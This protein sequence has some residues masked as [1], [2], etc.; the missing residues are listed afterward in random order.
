[1]TLRCEQI[2]SQSTFSATNT[3]LRISKLHPTGALHWMSVA[4]TDNVARNEQGSVQFSQLRMPLHRL[5]NSDLTRNLKIELFHHQSN[6]KHIYLAE[7]LITLGRYDMTSQSHIL[8][9]LLLFYSLTFLMLFCIPFSPSTYPFLILRLV[10]LC[11]EGRGAMGL[12]MENK[13]DVT[14]KVT[15]TIHFDLFQTYRTPSLEDYF[16]GGM[17]MAFSVAIEMPG[18]SKSMFTTND[19]KLKA[20]KKASDLYMDAIQKVGDVMVHF[21]NDGQ[22]PGFGFQ[23]NR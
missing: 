9:Y 12:P 11:A 14:K 20:L 10:Q 4:K 17:E 16:T 7:T 21:D 13:Q 8:P 3:F 2:E 23:G 15:T 1:M 5:A 18:H 19:S 22:F 6:G